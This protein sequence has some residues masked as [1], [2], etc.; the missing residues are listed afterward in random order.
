M[1]SDAQPRTDVLQAQ[2]MRRIQSLFDR[3]AAALE[4]TLPL[5]LAS[6]AV[7]PATAQE[8]QALD[9]GESML[10]MHSPGGDG[11]MHA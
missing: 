4:V 8:L 6:G 7:S 3:A 5:A 11:H 9:L 1:A 2:R 10:R